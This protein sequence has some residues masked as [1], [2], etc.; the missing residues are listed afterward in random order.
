[1]KRIA[2]AM[3]IVALAACGESKTNSFGVSKEPVSVRGW[4]ADIEGSEHANSP[5]MEIARLTQV[6]QGTQVW[7]DNAQYV[8]GGVAENGA[9][10]LLD[11][12]P[13]NVSIGFEAPGIGQIHVAL[14]NVPGNADVF[15]P[16]LI[17]KKNG[18]GFIKNE[19]VRVRLP[20]QVSKMTP[21]GK[22][23]SVAGLQVPVM[24]APIATMVD[25]HDY[26]QPGGFRPLATVR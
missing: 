3:L 11:V 10:I 7:V 23:A 1:M 26:P 18:A 6:F 9:F 5:E 19:D 21:T 8:S 25:R 24:N 22:T 2:L 17:L 16:G 4:I 12:P 20:A 13:G 15:L 14:K